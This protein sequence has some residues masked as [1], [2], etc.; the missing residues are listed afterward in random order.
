LLIFFAAFLGLT[1][2][3]ASAGY[4]LST[5]ND[6]ALGGLV[7][8]EDDLVR[9]DPINNRVEY[10]FEW[11]GAN[12]NMDAVSVPIQSAVWLLG[13]GLVGLIGLRKKRGRG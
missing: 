3:R 8:Q 12:E 13:S 6:A 7:F 5:Q 9:Y 2:V 11:T 1:P 10:F 4:I